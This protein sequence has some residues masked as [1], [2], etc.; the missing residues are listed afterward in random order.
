MPFYEV[1]HSLPLTPDQRQSLASS[2]TYLH[3]TAFTT[4]SFFVHVHFKAHDASDGSYFMAGKPRT[5]NSNR[6]IGIVRTS[7]ARS[8]S[9]FDTL[10]AKIE[11]TWYDV[12]GSWPGEGS[13]ETK[14][15]LMVTFV[16]MVTI[17]EG[18]MAIPEA[19][20]EGGWLKSQMP[21][22]REMGEERGVEDFADLLREMN[23]REDLKL[24]V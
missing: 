8:K 14:R 3:C 19:G 13:D 18:G 24:L 17:R 1:H 21:Y 2:I 11:E 10:A 12:V 6:I 4:P 7:P 22:I 16:P 5:T 15:L 20:H 23:E 9:D